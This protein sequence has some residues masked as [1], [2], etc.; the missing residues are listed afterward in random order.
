MKIRVD[1]MFLPRRPVGQRLPGLRKVTAR[2]TVT[3]FCCALG[4]GMVR[5]AL[6]GDPTVSGAD[7]GAFGTL[8]TEY[9]RD[10]QPLLQQ[11]CLECHSQEAVAGDLDLEQYATLA[12]VRRGPQVWV[13]VVEM[14]P[15]DA[16]QPPPR[17]RMKLLAWAHAEALAG[18]GDPGPVVLRRLNNAEYTYTVGDLTQVALDPTR[19]FPTDGAAGEGF[20]NT[21]NALVLSPALIRKYLDAGKE[22][23]AH[24]LLLLHG[25]RFS[26]H[27]SRRDCTNELLATIRRFYAEFS[28]I[29]P[30]ESHYGHSSTPLGNAGRLPIEKYFAVTL[31]QREAL[32]A[33]DK[34]IEA[35]AAEHGLNTRY[36]GL[37]WSQLTADDPSAYLDDLRSR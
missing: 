35:V 5:V 34:T 8:A 32:V 24:A 33:G 21:G 10:I 37:L 29:E 28:R 30:L 17:Q 9:E 23:A 1:L 12:E 2:L 15:E 26:P 6:L 22:I 7:L 20:T 27:V 3:L 16:P 11:F 18:E 19:K 36:L 31:S 25:F 13:K 14:P 4:G